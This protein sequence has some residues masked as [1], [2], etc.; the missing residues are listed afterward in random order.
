MI[1]KGMSCPFVLSN[2]NPVQ[3]TLVKM[4]QYGNLPH[5][6]K[7]RWNCEQQKFFETTT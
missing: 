2:F 6:K 7:N 4:K 5:K 3:K 1:H